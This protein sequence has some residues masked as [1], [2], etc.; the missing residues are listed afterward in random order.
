MLT[1]SRITIEKRYWN[2]FQRKN[3]RDFELQ[4]VVQP[5]KPTAC[6]ETDFEKAQNA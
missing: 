6:P 1:I 5:A 2:L 4:F 3:N